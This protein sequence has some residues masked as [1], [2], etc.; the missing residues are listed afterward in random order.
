MMRC[1]SRGAE[2]RAGPG[3]VGDWGAGPSTPFNAPMP[4]HMRQV[5]GNESLL[6][7]LRAFPNPEPLHA[8]Q[9]AAQTSTC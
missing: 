4:L 3:S 5:E 7:L 8:L 2:G 9:G 1:H 6:R